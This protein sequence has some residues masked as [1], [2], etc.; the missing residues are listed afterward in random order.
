MKKHQYTQ[1]YLLLL[2]I[3]SII[4]FS[5]QNNMLNQVFKLKEISNLYS[6]TSVKTEEKASLLAKNKVV[7][8]FSLTPLNEF[9]NQIINGDVLIG[10]KAFYAKLSLTNKLANTELTQNY[11]TLDVE[12]DVARKILETP[13]LIPITLSKLE[14]GIYLQNVGWSNISNSQQIDF[15]LQLYFQETL[16][17][18]Q[19]F[20]NRLNTSIESVYLQGILFNVPAGTYNVY[21]KL[22]PNKVV[23]SPRIYVKIASL[24]NGLLD[25]GNLPYFQNDE[26]YLELY[27]IPIGS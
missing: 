12:A 24:I 23:S 8:D 22:K 10:G 14:L 19:R 15:S 20:I 13:I 1:S 5:N 26:A 18:E 4:G 3:C 9:A 6:N 25:A 27:G 7:P 2:F 16:V 21:I 17:A 11:Y